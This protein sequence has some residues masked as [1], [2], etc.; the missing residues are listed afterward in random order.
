MKKTLFY[1]VLSKPIYIFTKERT[2]IDEFCYENGLS[3]SFNELDG[4][5]DVRTDVENW[6]IIKNDRGDF[7]LFHKNTRTKPKGHLIPGY[8]HQGVTKKQLIFCFEYI[9]NHRE[10]HKARVES[11]EQWTHENRRTAKKH[12][13]K[14]FM[15]GTGMD[16]KTKIY[17]KNYAS[18]TQRD[19]MIRNNRLDRI[20]AL[21]YEEEMRDY[22]SEHGWED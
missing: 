20:Q 14:S 18:K 17:S 5:I 9:A 16:H 4:S 15:N 1:S 10:K 22:V 8:H 7:V 19:R 11:W 13:R 3:Y 12:N 21:E 6:K 2:R